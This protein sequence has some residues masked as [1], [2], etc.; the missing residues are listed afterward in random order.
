[1][2]APLASFPRSDGSR[3]PYSLF[4]SP[5]IYDLEQERIYRGPTWNFLGLEAEIPNPFDFKS[6]FIGDTPMVMTRTEDGALAAW[7]NRCAHRGA[8]VCRLGERIV[9]LGHAAAAK[10]LVVRPN[11]SN[12]D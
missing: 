4:S 10:V 2:T 5:E 6:T 11:G 7:V 12:S 8:V 1:M 9:A 3:V